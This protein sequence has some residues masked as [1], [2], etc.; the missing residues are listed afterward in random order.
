LLRAAAAGARDCGA[1]PV[2]DAA[3]AALADRGERPEPVLHKHVSA[4]RLTG[5]ERQVLD[6]TAAG[7][8]VHQVAERLF[9][10]PG[11]VHVALATAA[12]KT[13]GADDVLK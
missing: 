13:A 5:R 2:L 3:V 12:A 10:T 1:R 7:L 8:D 4:G 11:T 6:L 9:L